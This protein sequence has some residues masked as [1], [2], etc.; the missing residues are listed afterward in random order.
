MM[1]RQF[2]LP[3]SFLLLNSCGDKKESI[4]PTIQPI[5]ESVYASGTVKS[6]NQ[7]QVFPNV[8]GIIDVIFVKEGDTVKAGQ[9][10][11][12]IYNMVQELNKENAELSAAYSDFNSNKGKL[13][14]AFLSIGLAKDKMY[15][16]SLLFSRQES[17]K[18]QGIG[19]EIEYE[20]SMLNYHNSKNAYYSAKVRYDDLKR[21]IDFNSAQSKKNVQISSTLANDLT[22]VSQIDGVIY[23]LTKEE[24]EM[25]NTQTALAV[26]GDATVFELEMQVDENDILKIK[27]GQQ[28]FVTLD[29][30]EDLSFEG[31]IIQI[32]PMMNQSTKTFT[33]TAKFLEQPEV[34]YPNMNF[35][36]SIVIQ[37]KE[38]AMLIPRNYLINDSL[39]VKSNGDTVA[40]KTGLKD[41][42]MVEILS[43]ISATDE[44][45][46][47]A[48]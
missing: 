27:I 36:A 32:D 5:T 28:V 17:L 23:N 10:I 35:E 13:N 31:S 16:D 19:T 20:Q 26:I 43:G 47:P 25:V 44:I 18:A 38:D 33:V 8:S 29:S 14:D 4:T 34:L 21:Q 11:L 15:N 9:P 48:K 42:K 40:V 22:V 3:L 24:G 7:Y 39:V 41:Y 37:T 45:T 12:K 30:Y 1:F 6:K 46:K 2:I